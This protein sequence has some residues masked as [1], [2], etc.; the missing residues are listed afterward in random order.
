MRDRSSAYEVSTPGAAEAT[1]ISNPRPARAGGPAALTLRTALLYIP[2][3]VPAWFI[4]TGTLEELL[5][6]S[7]LHLPDHGSDRDQR[8]M[9]DDEGPQ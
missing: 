6:R 7:S 4:V 2:G 1:D 8:L 3:L 9:E 5:D